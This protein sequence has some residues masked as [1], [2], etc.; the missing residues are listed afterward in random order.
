MKK[1]KAIGIDYSLN[2]PAICIATGDLSFENCKFYYVSSKKKYIGNFG[3]NII[4]SEYKEWTDP[5]QRFNNL[6]NWA[7]KS[8]RSYGDMN[9][10][11]GQ[12]TVHIEGYSYGSKGQAIFQIAENCGILKHVLLS[13][14]LK[15]VTVAPS[16]VK[17][18]ATDKGNANKELMYEQFCKDTKTDLMKMM[19]MQTLSNPVTDIVDAYYIARCGYESIKVK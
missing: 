18:F 9:L 8:M 7:L 11:D 2:S 4:G 16:I 10:F 19:D 12:Q 5:I 1:I 14:K 3:K 15:Y 17:K 6:A 13:K